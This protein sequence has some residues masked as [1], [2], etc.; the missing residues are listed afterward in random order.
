MISGVGTSA[1]TPT[2]ATI[3]WTTNEASDT[4]V[5]YGTTTAYGSS[6]QLVSTLTTNHSASLS[7]LQA[8]KLYHYRVKSRDGAGNLATSG[9][10]TFTTPTT[11]TT[12][13][14]IS[15]VG[16]SSLTSSG[17]TVNWT[18]NEVS[19]T[20]VEYGATTHYGSSTTLV[21]SLVTSHSTVLS[22]L[23]A[24]KLYHYRVKSRDGAGN[25]AVS[26]DFTFTTVAAGGGLVAAYGF[27]EGRGS[28]VSDSSG[29]SN[30]GTTSG[31]TWSNPGKFG[32]ALSF[33]GVN[34]YVTIANSSSLN[35][36]GTNL[37]ISFWVNIQNLGGKDDVIISKP[38]FSSSMS[39]PYYQYGVEFDANG[40]KTLDFYFGDTSGTEHGPFSMT[41][42]L[43]SWTYVTFTY[44]GVAVKGYLDGV[45]K[46]ST[47]TTQDIQARGNA[48][49]LGIDAASG[50]PFAGKLDEVRIYNRALSQT[51]IQSDMNTP[52]GGTAPQISWTTNEASNTQVSRDGA[53]NVATSGD[54]TFATTSAA[55]T[56]PPVI[57]SVDAS[58]V[59]ANGTTIKWT[60]NEASDTQVEY[61][62]TNSYGSSTA[63]NA[64]RVTI[65]RQGIRGLAA[66]S[67]YHYRVKSRDA[68]GNLAVSADFKFHTASSLGALFIPS[69]VEN[70]RF[71]TNVG[72][73]NLSSSNANVKLTLLNTE[74]NVAASRMVSVGP[75]GLSQINNVARVL[76]S[77][78]LPSAIQG[79]LILESDQEI[80]A[81][82]A[83]INN[84][85]NDP[86]FLQGRQ[87]G[88]TKILIPSAA[89]LT[90]FKSSLTV[91]NIGS[92]SAQVSLKSHNVNG[93]VI[94]QTQVPISLS[95]SASVV[96]ENILETL[97][98]KDAFGPIEITS[99]NDVPLLAVSRVSGANQSGGFFEG[100][101]YSEAS[102]FQII[103][104]VAQNAERRTNIGINNITDRTA[105]VWV[106]LKSKGGSE[107]GVLHVLVPPRGLTQL[108][109]V[110]RE[111][112]NADMG[113]GLEGF[114]E[115]YS[116][117][118]ILAWASQID[119]RT[120]DPAFNV[121]QAQGSSGLLFRS[122]NLGNFRSSLVVVN[123][124]DVEAIVD[125][126]S[127]D[128]S[129]EIRGK[130]R[131][132]SIPA[133]G[134]FSSANVLQT[135]GVSQ[136][137]GTVE[138]ISTNGQ[139]V[140]ATSRIY[141]NSRT[142]GFIGGQ[143]LR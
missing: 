9:D 51:E 80:R 31:P 13:P 24:S 60:T 138:I 130:L 43:G 72:I 37:T 131:G 52:I 38:W 84:S 123:G 18:T 104:S 115:L 14:V 30:S 19:D 136:G 73:S 93:E 110:A 56:N 139:P 2:A 41:P 65:H 57:S 124:N 26:V 5:E 22:G 23:Q 77:D 1:I 82:A 119:N 11:D 100:L 68:A 71:R 91:M 121:A 78:Q 28:I 88:S 122:T 35:I 103:P 48:L 70:R 44:D 107:L 8:S 36:A 53:G 58:L 33:D 6:T 79:S 117:Q 74:G 75:L 42:S 142:S 98:V 87:K 29:N 125:M 34:D 64:S 111:L 95:P 27:N 90:S 143:E 109:D 106:R 39:A 86:S 10:F 17:A 135:L 140:I 85:N 4:Q 92:E 49:R 102:T 50:Q 116:D 16:A 45:Q 40:A 63:L 25:L 105:S 21:T 118:P 46:F 15:G 7:G 81:W 129:G 67:L 128:E 101:D 99:L 89:N 62:L 127:R 120:N 69:I 96:F 113:A 132:L 108:N 126:V 133:K 20:Q 83:Q 141:S 76:L 114:I 3:S 94:G 66:G 12:P 54:I 32:N 55:D 61:G 137:S 112:V 59:T 47:R 97:G 134:Y